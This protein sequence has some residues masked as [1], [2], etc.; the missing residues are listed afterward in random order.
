MAGE[1]LG[2]GTRI[3]VIDDFVHSATTL[4]TAVG[5]LHEVGLV[6]HTTSALL[7]SPPEALADAINSLQVRLTALAVSS[8]L[9]A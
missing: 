9:F 1:R 3:H 8:E 5:T 6:V 7:A 4:R 2:F